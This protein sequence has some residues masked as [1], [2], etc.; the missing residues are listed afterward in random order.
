M[1]GGALDFPGGLGG[2]R[3]PLGFGGL[4][5]E[6]GLVVGP[7]RGGGLYISSVGRGWRAGVSAVLGL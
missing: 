5:D 4:G 7:G 3:A 6:G 2:W 1:Q